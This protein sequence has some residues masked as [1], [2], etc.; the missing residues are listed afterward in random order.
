MCKDRKEDRDPSSLWRYG[1]GQNEAHVEPQTI[2]H[3]NTRQQDSGESTK[4]RNTEKTQERCLVIE[5][6]VR[7]LSEQCLSHGGEGINLQETQT[8]LEGVVDLDLALATD[9][10]HTTS[11]VETMLSVLKLNI[12]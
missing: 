6:P 9:N 1:D 2:K 5:T 10:N 3:R 7:V 4:W 11:T 12:A 8:L